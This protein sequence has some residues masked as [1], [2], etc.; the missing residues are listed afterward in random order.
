M[1][2]RPLGLEPR[3]NGL[4]GGCSATQV[5]DVIA[6]L[7]GFY[8]AFRL[9]VEDRDLIQNSAFW[10][11]TLPFL[12]PVQ[13]FS[14]VFSSTSWKPFF[15]GAVS[16]C[17]RLLQ[18]YRSADGTLLVWDLTGIAGV[19]PSGPQATEEQVRGTWDGLEPAAPMCALAAPRVLAVALDQTSTLLRAEV[20]P[21]APYDAGTVDRLLANLASDTFFRRASGRPPI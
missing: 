16:N 13:N 15:T 7:E 20:Y 19:A 6:N 10:S 1:T 17:V 5:C 14:P 12:Y 4:K 18:R 2:V 11:K 9:P 21:V 3:T 8:L